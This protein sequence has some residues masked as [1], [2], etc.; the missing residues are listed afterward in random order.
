MWK[1]R[2]I[3]D[4]KAQDNLNHILGNYVRYA[5][6]SP[7]EYPKK[8]RLSDNDDLRPMS[9]EEMEKQARKNTIKMGGVVNDS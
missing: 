1:E 9:D 3:D 8:P 5:F 7:G 2:N 6:N 4:S